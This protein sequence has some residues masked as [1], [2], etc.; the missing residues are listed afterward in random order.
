MN[1]TP[2]TTTLIAPEDHSWLNSKHGTDSAK[3]VRLDKTSCVAL[4]TD[5]IVKSG[6]VLG[7]ISASSKYGPYDDTA[8]DGRQTAVGI[9]YTTVDVGTSGA[10]N[11][12]DSAASLLRHCEVLAS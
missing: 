7:K 6:T 5:G 10:G 3:T 9:L 11:L 2:V 1:L 12:H 8:S 4:Y